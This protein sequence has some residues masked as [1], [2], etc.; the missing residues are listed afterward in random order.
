MS[1][2]N[3][4]MGFLKSAIGAGVPLKEAAKTAPVQ[5]GVYKLYL[6]GRLMK[7]GKAEWEKGIRWRMQQYWRGDRTTA[8][9]YRQEIIS[10]RDNI[11]AS[12]ILCPKGE[13]RA[14]EKKQIDEAGGVGNLPWCRR[15]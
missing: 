5:T 12:W 10:N 15:R 14:L 13:C 2:L 7:I 9:P 11:T 4:M 1:F 3:K 6:N 8:G